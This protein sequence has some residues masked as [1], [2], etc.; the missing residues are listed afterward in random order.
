[1]WTLGR[2]A[3]GLEAVNGRRAGNGFGI[4][5]YHRVTDRTP[6]YAAPTWNMPPARLRSQL[7]GLYGADFSRGP[8]LT[9]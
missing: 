2:T 8:C 5:T 6:G 9:Y 7:A 3:A 4:L 1:M